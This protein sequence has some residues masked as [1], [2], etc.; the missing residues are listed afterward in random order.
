MRQVSYLEHYLFRMLHIDNLA[1]YLSEGIYAPNAK[2]DPT[3]VSIGDEVLI[4]QRSEFKVPIEPGGVLSDYVPFYFWGCSPMLL[5]IKTGHRGIK[6]LSQSKIV[7]ICVR[8]GV[9]IQL[10]RDFCFTDGHAKDKLTTYYN[11]ADDLSQIDW[12]A[13]KAKYWKSTEEDP[14]KM[15]RKQAEFLIKNYVPVKCFSGVIVH[16]NQVGSEV[17]HIMKTAGTILPIYIDT[18]HRYYYND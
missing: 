11:C 9:A 8:I 18:N 15:R 16:D 1:K 17:G 12:Q 2:Y 5:N 10:C 4:A 6:Q 3:Y 7:Y 14:D 13:V